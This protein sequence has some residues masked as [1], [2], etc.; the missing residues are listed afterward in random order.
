[1]DDIII[2]VIGSGALSA[3][4]S[5]IFATANNR[6]RKKDGVA[7]GVQQLMYDRIKYLC[8]AHIT[9]GKIATNDLEDLERMHKIYHDDLHGNGYLKDLMEQVRHLKVVPVLPED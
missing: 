3:V 8:K 7:A 9:R 1:M 6:K 2:A 4:I 5:G